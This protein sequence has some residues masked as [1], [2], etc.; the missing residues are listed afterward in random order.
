MSLTQFFP[1]LTYCCC[2]V[3]QPRLTL[4]KPMDCSTPGFPVLH[5]LLELA[6]THVHWV[7]GAIQPSRSLHPFLPPSVLPIIRIFFNESTLCI[8]WPKYWSFSFSISPSNEYS[9]LI[10]FKS[11]W[12]DLLAV[13][14]TLKIL[15]QH[16]SSEASVK[17]LTL[18][19]LYGPTLTSTHDYWKTIALIRWIFVSKIWFLL[20][21]M[22]SRLVI[23][24]HPRSKRLLISWLQSP[25]A[26]IW[27]PPKRVC[28]CFH[29][30][31]MYL[32]WS[33]ITLI[34]KICQNW[35]TEIG[36]CVS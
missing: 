21:N 32:P 31:P 16:H 15:L 6:Q 10:S 29:C 23:A 35:K 36:K 5:H 19:F 33:G 11:D 13:Q 8:R 2:T 14:G 25:S 20:F 9:G 30:F 1:L 18:S 17:A 28:H 22:L 7:A 12:C 4:C 26:V 3:T 24:F 27:E 34:Q